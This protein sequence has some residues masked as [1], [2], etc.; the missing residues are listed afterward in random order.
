MK[1]DEIIRRRKLRELRA[2][3]MAE[4]LY[5]KLNNYGALTPEIKKMLETM[6]VEMKDNTFKEIDRI[7]GIT[8][9]EE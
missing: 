8:E 4:Y 3:D 5:D 6:I 1:R 2:I 9:M 7:F